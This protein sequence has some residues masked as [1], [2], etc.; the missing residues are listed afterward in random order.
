MSMFYL[1]PPPP[2]CWCA[3]ACLI[4]GDIFS[5]ARPEPASSARYITSS[6]K[7]TV[8][9]GAPAS[10]TGEG[11]RLPS[12]SSVCHDPFHLGHDPFH[13]NGA[14]YA[15]FG[16]CFLGFRSTPT[17]Q[18][19]RPPIS[20]WARIDNICWTRRKGTTNANVW[21]VGCG[22]LG[23]HFTPLGDKV[24]FG[25][26]GGNNNKFSYIRWMQF[27]NF[28]F[29]VFWFGTE[30]RVAALVYVQESCVICKWSWRA[31]YFRTLSVAR[32]TTTEQSQH[33]RLACCLSSCVVCIYCLYFY[34]IVGCTR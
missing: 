13:K 2:C 10:A 31:V 28:I 1:Q 34:S 19:I 30:G 12:S 17:V 25:L 26:S 5:S 23:G 27:L 15:C 14:K 21:L 16:I 32:I 22:T 24:S 29:V 9:L 11:G 20:S 8:W 33:L 7:T 6:S 3:A 4:M 18:R